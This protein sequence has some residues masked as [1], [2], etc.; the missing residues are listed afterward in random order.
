M[1]PKCEVTHSLIWEKTW[2]LVCYYP[3]PLSDSHGR[4][5]GCC[6]RSWSTV[7]LKHVAAEMQADS[8]SGCHSFRQSRGVIGRFQSTSCSWWWGEGHQLCTDSPCPRESIIS[9]HFLFLFI[10]FTACGWLLW[11]FFFISKHNHSPV[12]Y[13]VF[14]ESVTA[15][16]A[17]LKLLQ[18]LLEVCCNPIRVN[19]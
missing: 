16:A 6:S 10:G 11:T 3:I 19:V 13:F 8:G 12:L 4:E 9:P 14:W 17:S 7:L 5:Q 15:Q 2:S 1:L 18:V